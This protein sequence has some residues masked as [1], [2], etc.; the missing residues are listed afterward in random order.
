LGEEK[1][2]SLTGIRKGMGEK[3]CGGHLTG[4]MARDIINTDIGIDES[5]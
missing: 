5:P 1:F 2:G 3:G 4:V